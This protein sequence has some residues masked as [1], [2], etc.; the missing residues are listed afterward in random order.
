MTQGDRSFLAWNKSRGCESGRNERQRKEGLN[1]KW[2]K[3]TRKIDLKKILVV[4]GERRE[5][6]SRQT[7]NARE[8]KDNLD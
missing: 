8:S 5:E 3:N 1:E 6:R 4:G 7:F 2:R